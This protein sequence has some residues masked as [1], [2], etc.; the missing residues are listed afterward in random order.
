MHQP[1]KFGPFPPLV[2]LALTEEEV[3]VVVCHSQAKGLRGL[4]ALQEWAV[5]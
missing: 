2:R 4:S 3:T 1:A 5:Q